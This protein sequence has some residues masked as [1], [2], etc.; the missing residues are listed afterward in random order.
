[1]VQVLIIGQDISYGTQLL[2]ILHHGGYHVHLV[3]TKLDGIAFFLQNEY[4]MLLGGAAS[5]ER[6][7]IDF[8]ERIKGL[9]STIKTG[10]IIEKRTDEF[11][12]SLV[13]STIDFYLSKEDSLLKLCKQ[14]ER[15]DQ[16]TGDDTPKGAQMLY[17]VDEGLVVDLSVRVVYKD[18]KR[19][20]LNMKEYELLV[21]LLKN[22]GRALSRIALHTR[23]HRNREKVGLRLVDKYVKALRNKLNTKS[24]VAIRGY[25]YK[26]QA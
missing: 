7:M 6:E 13:K 4:D 24:I 20:V 16:M 9:K 8:L 17:E 21:Y 26:W 11:C 25:G 3:K 1:M 19:I 15:I 5:R 22:K 12:E 2:Q 18:K 10:L 14:W 23:M